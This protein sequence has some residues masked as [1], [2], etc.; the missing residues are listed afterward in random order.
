MK[1]EDIKPKSS[2]FYL[3]KTQTEYRLRPWTLED[4][5]WLKEEYGDRIN[6]IFNEKHI[7]I[8]AISRMA[9]RLLTDKSD[10]K[11]KQ[12]KDFNE[13]GEEVTY[14]VGGY[15]L[16]INTVNDLNEQFALLSA[17][18]E[19][20]GLNMPQLEELKNIDLEVGEKKTQQKL[21]KPVSK[22]GERSLTY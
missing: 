3:S 9:Y 21:K 5:I 17:V 10:F 19:S 1:L 16:L 8:V 12:I 20:I 14:K 18:I 6:E 7:D 22:T 11:A 2:K 4:Q 15:K 13:D